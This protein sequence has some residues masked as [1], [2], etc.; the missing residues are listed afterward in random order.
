MIER[1]HQN[2]PVYADIDLETL[3]QRVNARRQRHG[4]ALQAFTGIRQSVKPLFK[5]P[6]QTIQRLPKRYILHTVVAL[7]VP[8]AL[9]LSQLPTRPLFEPATS[10]V[11]VAQSPLGLGPVTIETN[12]PDGSRIGDPPIPRDAIPVPLSL[13]SRSEA[14][15]PVVV[16][17][18]TIVNSEIKLRN[19]PGLEYDEVQR[20]DGGESLQVIGRYGEWLHVSQ[21]NQGEFWVARELVDISDSA[22]YTLFEVQ[23]SEI[24]PP[25]PPKVAQVRETGLNL[26]DGPGTNYVGMTKLEAGETI[27][28]IEQ[29][30]D[31]IRVA[32]DDIEGWV[33]AEYLDMV[34]G[35]IERVPT[36]ENI[37]DPNPALVGTVNANSVN[38]REG[39]GT[40]YG[41]AGAIDSGSQLDL[42]ARYKDW[43]KVQTASGS[44]AWVF[45]ELL[46]V[47][48]MAQRR[49]PY[50]SNIPA[51]PAPAPAPVV[52]SRSGGSTAAPAR[53]SSN[54]TTSPA[55]APAAPAPV[56]PAPAPAP[57]PVAV[58][59]SGDVAGFALQYVG[60]PY[61]YGAS[62]PGAFDCSG[63]TSYVYRQF[64]VYLP[65]NAAAQFST[66]YGANVGSMANLAPGD[67]V[68]F[69][70]T[71]GPGISHVGL[72]IGGG[73]VVHAL[74]PGYGVQVTSLYESYWISHYAGA[75]RPYR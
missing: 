54:T 70:G 15:A 41:K 39:P 9:G 2:L 61:V 44:T 68:F 43:F 66:A 74:M 42:L 60:Y 71:A 25:P 63:F 58:P 16:P 19:G 48:P 69:A 22:I 57:A 52:A 40:A 62:G 49:V 53:S 37:P 38:L 47:E 7:V 23:D 10:S 46:N 5:T 14:L 17:A 75:I 32:N 31:W 67:L 20:L 33:S 50:T 59:A 45:G 8:V 29:Y 12:L 3:Q 6:L 64:G 4:Q 56:A 13:T 11:D 65:H 30:Q 27:S 34:P 35:V 72:H 24:P 51:L 73:R 55:P 18:Q 1:T 26:R 36:T 28:L 21:G